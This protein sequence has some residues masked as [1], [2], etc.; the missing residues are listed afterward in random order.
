MGASDRTL[1]KLPSH[2][3]DSRKKKKKPAKSQ[4]G[5]KSGGDSTFTQRPAWSLQRPPCSQRRAG[6]RH[7]CVGIE[8]PVLSRI[9]VAVHPAAYGDKYVD[10]PA[11]N[12]VRRHR[13][14]HKRRHCEGVGDVQGVLT[15]S[16]GGVDGSLWRK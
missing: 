6:S 14:C 15:L 3:S 10:V 13:R 11:C 16:C 9:G 1:Y 12:F 7:A 8:L 5:Q 2:A 4:C